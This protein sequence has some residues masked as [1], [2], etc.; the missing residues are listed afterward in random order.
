M[1][2]YTD[3]LDGDVVVLDGAEGRHAAVRRLRVG[4][5]VSVGDGC[6][7]VASCVVTRSGPGTPI[8]LAVTSRSQAPPADP[9]V[10]VI[11]AIPK[12]DRGELAVEE[13]TEVGAD[14]IVPWSAARCVAV[15]ASK[16]DRGLERWRAK[17]RESAKQSLRPWIPSVTDPVTT[18]SAAALVSAASLAVVLT[19]GA[20]QALGAVLPPASGSIVV[21]I[22]PEGGITEDELAQLQAAGARA[23]RLGPSVLR[24]STA[25]AV[26][27]A[28]LLSR[29]PGWNLSLRRPGPVPVLREVRSG[30]GSSGA[31]GRSGR[32]RGCR[33]DARGPGREI[34][35]RGRSGGRRGSRGRG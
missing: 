21:I 28:V 17:A 35:R 18:A 31:G 32:R 1:L 19:P 7:L 15:W 12:G 20:D 3:R 10:T 29:T 14:T 33:G 23:C 34:R 26:A 2:F 5:A 9:S 13:M 22:G 16:T 6:G 8:E 11:Q 27:A 25:G 4:E 24:T 30:T